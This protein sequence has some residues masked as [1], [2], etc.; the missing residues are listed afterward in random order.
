MT[1]D[2]P[3]DV[4]NSNILY[5]ID[6]YVRLDR[7]KEILRLHWF[8]GLSLY[9]LAQR[10]DLSLTTIKNIVYSQGDAVLIRASKMTK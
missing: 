5:C 1:H 4:L 6:E 2:I 10:Y 9:A 7:D 3:E 8:G